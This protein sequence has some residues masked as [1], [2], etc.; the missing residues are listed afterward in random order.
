[1][2]DILGITRT[3]LNARLSALSK[4][5]ILEIRRRQVVWRRT[6]DPEIA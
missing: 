6:A 2:S 4:A 3:H 5:G 1:M